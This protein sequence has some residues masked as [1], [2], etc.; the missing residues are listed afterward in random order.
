MLLI[1]LKQCEVALAGGRLEEACGLLAE[2]AL[3]AHRRGQELLSSVSKA[4]VGRGRTHLAAGSLTAAAED[5]DRA[6]GLGGNLAEVVQLRR[7]VSTAMSEQRKASQLRDHVI[8]TARRHADAGQITIGQ[9]MIADIAV[10]GDH[11][12][13]LKQDLVARRASV[14]S[15]VEKATAALKSDDWEA[16]ID[17]VARLDRTSRCEQPV[18][19]IVGRI[20]QVVMEQCTDAINSGRLDVASSLLARLNHLPSQSSEAETLR[21]VLMQC[22]EAFDAIGKGD[23]AIAELSLR[24]L[25]PL[26]P[27]AK[28]LS[29]A[30][31]QVRT[32]RE[33]TEELRTGPLRLAAVD[34]VA[35]LAPARV[36]PPPLPRPQA[37][38]MPATDVILHVDGAGG[39]RVIDRPIVTIGPV[40]SSRPV[41][42][43]LMADAMLPV[44]TIARS[45]DDYF[46]HAVQPVLVNDKPTTSTL[47]SNGDRIGLGPR[48]RITFRR[49]SPASSSAVLDLSG[50]RLP[51]ADVRHIILMDREMIVGPGAAAHV[52]SDELDAPAVIQRR[53]GRLICRN[54]GISTELTPGTHVKVGPIGLV[55]AKE[56]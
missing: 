30:V 38:P 22:R 6:A 33:A 48:C 12:E 18:R 35:T 42:V 11:A 14:D 26:V 20:N 55:V 19:E 8:A 54:Q 27:R 1:R 47:L 13:I 41:D 15:A 51:Q 10:V 4:L 32:L 52:R 2:P 53:D 46:L 3:R 29:T 34:T 39:F 17:H 49:P 21:R 24:A 45:E 37:K 23:P 43:P 56:A 44:I 36:L 31:E 25:L 9:Q 16:A 28:W 7:A 5:A 40:S 50:T